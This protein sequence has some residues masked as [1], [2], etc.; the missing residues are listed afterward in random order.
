M[1]AI[2]CCQEAFPLRH[3]T[4]SFLPS[5]TNRFAHTENTSLSKFTEGVLKQALGNI[6][7]S[8]ADFHGA[9]T[10]FKESI[11]VT[12]DVGDRPEK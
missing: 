5:Y 8:A 9:V 6:C 2:H 1:P 7:R 3:P 4:M 12:K 10:C 11:T